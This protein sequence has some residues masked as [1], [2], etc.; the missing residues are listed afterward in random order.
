MRI[1]LFNAKIKYLV[2]PTNADKDSSQRENHS[3]FDLFHALIS[4]FIKDDKLKVP[5]GFADFPE[6]S[7][8]L[9][10]KAGRV[11]IRQ[12]IQAYVNEEWI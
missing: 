10:S 9:L 4:A 6:G 11:F 8:C 3:A 7:D 2:R 12:R 1:V 5:H